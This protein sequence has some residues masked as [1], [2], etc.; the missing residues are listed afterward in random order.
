MGAMRD[1]NRAL[2]ENYC[3]TIVNTVG[4][5]YP[6]YHDV[7]PGSVEAPF[8]IVIGRIF[9]SSVLNF[10]AWQGDVFVEVEA[11]GFYS[12]SVGN[13]VDDMV[14]QIKFGMVKGRASTVL[15]MGNFYLTAFS[16][17]SDIDI[18]VVETENGLMKRR[19]VRFKQTIVDNN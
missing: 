19:I 7:L 4:V 14:D 8:Y 1:F 18:P 6:V 5:T 12:S 16:W 10:N 3:G 11:I 13:E 9:S 2:R 17:D 15:A